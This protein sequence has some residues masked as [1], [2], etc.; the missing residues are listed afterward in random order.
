MITLRPAETDPDLEAWRQVRLAI[1]PDERAPTVEELRRK[2]SPERLLI[3]AERGGDV[4]GTG[5]AERSSHAGRVFVAPRVRPEARR[6]GIGTALL[7]RLVGHG[8]ALGAA[9]LTAQVEC[10]DPGSLS[11]AER[12]AFAEVDR[13]VEQVKILGNEQPP[14]FPPGVEVVT[15]AAR[16]ELLRAAYDLAVQAYSYMATPWPASIALDEWLREEATHPA[17]S[18]VALANGE[19][20]GYS[21][22]MRDHDDPAKAEDGLTAV[23]RDWRRRGLATA[24]KRAELAWAAGS[25]LREVYT[26]T[27]RGNEGMRRVNEGL[28]YRYRHVS[29]T[30]SAPLAA[31]ERALASSAAARIN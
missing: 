15:V 18:F 23:R 10:S 24:L 11:F 29:V 2:P 14:E 27:Q 5:V 17:G 20:V 16:P 7:R 31:A 22:L 12:F 26:W 9:A 4:V 6:R 13:Q 28:G 25:G 3:L 1:V 19:I 21:G 30:L 8:S